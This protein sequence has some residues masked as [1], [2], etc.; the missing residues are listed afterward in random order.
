MKKQK[1]IAFMLFAL[2]LAVNYANAQEKSGFG[3]SVITN[4]ATIFFDGDYNVFSAGAGF[5]FS[6]MPN[7]SGNFEAGFYVAP[8]FVGEGNDNS[9]F[10]SA[11]I[12]VTVFRSFGLGLG[13]RL[14]K[15]GDGFVKPKKKNIFL[16]L[17]L[18][19]TNTQKK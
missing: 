6:Y 8:Q 7:D 15:Q 13:Y 4:V 17:G 19:L 5:G 14:W 12:H 11:L 16:T 2:L 1:A 9:G 18:G 3:G 10:V